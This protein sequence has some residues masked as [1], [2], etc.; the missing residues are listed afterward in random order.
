MPKRRSDTMRAVDA[1]MPLV[2][3]FNLLDD[4]DKLTFL[5]LVDPLPEK[6]DHRPKKRANKKSSKSSQ[7]S[8]SKSPRASGMAAQLK[9]RRQQ[10]ETPD[11]SDDDNRFDGKSAQETRRELLQD[12]DDEDSYCTHQYEHDGIMIECGEPADQNIH[13]LSTTEGY[14]PFVS[15]SGA[16]PAPASSPANG[17]GTNGTVSS[18][19][20]KDAASNVHHAGG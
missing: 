9:E 10:R 11:D 1:V 19:I 7:Q 6:H 8:S 4:G 2:D 14:H 18:E 15:E 20:A 3:E 16:P 5:D 12:I 17:E 13:H